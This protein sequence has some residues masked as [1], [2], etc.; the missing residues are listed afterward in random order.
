MREHVAIILLCLALYVVWRNKKDE[1]PEG[2]PWWE[3]LLDLSAPL[4]AVTAF[5]LVLW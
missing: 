3:H 2:W 1:S 4:A 5:V